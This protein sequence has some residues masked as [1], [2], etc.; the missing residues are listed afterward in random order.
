MNPPGVPS[1]LQTLN[2]SSSQ[3]QITYAQSSPTLST[4]TDYDNPVEPTC[5]NNP[6][7]LN[8]DSYHSTTASP[9]SWRSQSSVLASPT[10]IP[11][12]NAIGETMQIEAACGSDSC[13]GDYSNIS[14]TTYQTDGSK[15]EL[16]KTS[17]SAGVQAI[18]PQRHTDESGPLSQFSV[19]HIQA[20]SVNYPHTPWGITYKTL[21]RQQDQADDYFPS[22][23]RKRLAPEQ[24]EIAMSDD[25]SNEVLP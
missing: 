10:S 22:P 4:G 21:K 18:V 12:H 9:M 3:P 16:S 7:Q 20:N 6:A 5:S 14:D 11:N 2:T 25:I 19:H 1:F 13:Q 17:G 24:M 8:A 15:R 23:A